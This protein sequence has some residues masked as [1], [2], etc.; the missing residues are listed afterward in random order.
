M[1]TATMKLW[2]SD[3]ELFDLV[4]RELF[5]AV[6]GD[7]MDKIGL[8]HQFLPPQI[9]P[10]RSEMVVISR[11]MPVLEVDVFMVKRWSNKPSRQ[12]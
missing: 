12:V 11:A 4:R 3:E 10:I 5:T 2:S 7:V 9:K 1:G 8:V 6:A